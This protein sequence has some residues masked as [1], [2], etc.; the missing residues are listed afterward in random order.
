[1]RKYHFNLFAR[2]CTNAMYKVDS[3]GG[4]HQ[5]KTY[6]SIFTWRVLR[7][8]L[9]P[10]AVLITIALLI[11][12]VVDTS[13]NHQ[14]ARLQSNIRLYS[15][16]NLLDSS[17][18]DV[19]G[20][21][22]DVL[23]LGGVTYHI[24]SSSASTAESSSTTSS[25]R[26]PTG[27]DNGEDTSVSTLLDAETATGTLA[28]AEDIDGSESMPVTL[29]NRKSLV[30]GR[31]RLISTTQRTSSIDRYSASFV[32]RLLSSFDKNARSTER[33]TQKDNKG[34][35]F[36][37]E[38]TV[39]HRRLPNGHKYGEYQAPP[40]RGS[41]IPP[42]VSPTLPSSK[43]LLHIVTPPQLRRNE[44]LTSSD[45]ICRSPRLSMCRGVLP[46]D[47]TALPTIPG[48]SSELD[49]DAAMPYFDMILSTGCSKRARQFLCSLLEPE[50]QD[51]GH[52]VLP[53]CRKACKVVA[54]ECRSY[55]LDVLDL[56]QVFQCDIY[57]DLNYPE[58]CVN[59]A[60]EDTCLENE[61]KCPDPSGTCIPWRWV[62]DNKPDC[63]QGADEVNCTHCAQNQFRCVSDHKCILDVWRCDGNMDCA[64]GSDEIDC[65]ADVLIPRSHTSPCPSGEL[66][67]VDGRCITL[68]QICDRVRDCS[69]GAD[70]ANCSLPFT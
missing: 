31:S 42:P 38:S 62:C 37:K 6:D 44:S 56:S 64:D 51:V 5:D 2:P 63:V 58:Q 67:C 16:G 17:P 36:N 66:R 43:S 23:D 59:L 49:L 39:F 50:C 46:W 25:T 9:V 26:P 18:D 13:D 45:S 19:I 47:L 22:G 35:H 30:T 68:Q 3:G 57:P 52:N 32:D 48:L 70:E 1:M 55:I 4:H 7:W 15:E 21:D 61:F 12:F 28:E 54:E 53:P 69:D 40:P 41:T 34:G 33:T 29:K 8:A 24:S 11:S 65:Q 14:H 20:L 27:E 60:K 10:A